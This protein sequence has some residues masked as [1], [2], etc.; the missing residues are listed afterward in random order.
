M[1]LTYLGLELKRFFRDPT[2]VFF[3]AVLPCFLYVI[4]GAAQDYSTQEIGHGNV[5]FYVMISM[6]AYGAVTATV[7]LG[8]GAAVER[9]QGWGRQLGLTPMRDST[10][11]VS[12]ALT[13]LIIALIPVG[14]I[15][16]IAAFTGARGEIKP[17]IFGTVT[18]LVGAAIFSIFGLIFGLT[19][20]GEAA[21]GAAGGS[22]VILAFLGN[23]FFPL[24]GALLTVAKFTPLYGL[25]SLARRPITDGYLAMVDPSAE[26]IFEPLWQPVTNAIVWTV[27]LVGLAV[28]VVRRGR[29]RQ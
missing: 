3:I 1:N 10:V 15:Y 21:A 24:S 29:G 28:L 26:P 6:A 9:M 20:R 18:V 7:S 12:K 14:E 19:I 13:G 23:L 11:V 8:A 5:A 22:L 4:F 25:A 16:I 17:W 2:G 27:V